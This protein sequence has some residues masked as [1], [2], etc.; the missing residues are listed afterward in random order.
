MSN[1]EAQDEPFDHEAVMHGHHRGDSSANL[2]QSESTLRVDE[3]DHGDGFY[4]HSGPSKSNLYDD[5][6]RTLPYD[7]EGGPKNYQDFGM[8]TVTGKSHITL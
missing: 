7:K 1:R 8:Y 3:Y 5:P 6:E 4:D 2:L